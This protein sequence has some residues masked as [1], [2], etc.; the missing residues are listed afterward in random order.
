MPKRVSILTLVALLL[1][2]TL[3]AQETAITYQGQLHENGEPFTG[4]ANLQFQLYDAL[5]GGNQRFLEVWVDGA[6]LSPRQKV[7]ATP[8]ALLA[9]GTLSGGGG[10]G[11]IDPSEVQLRVTDNCPAG[12]YVREI[13]QNGSVV[14]GID[15]APGSWLR[16]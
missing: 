2:L 12:Q 15:F 10:G 11:E 14:C 16:S 5:L 13:G 4:T 9:A 8:F 6:P 3:A 1:P 7:T